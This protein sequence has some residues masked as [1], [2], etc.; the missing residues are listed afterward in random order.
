MT[1]SLLCALVLA[2]PGADAG[3]PAP[4]DTEPVVTG[5]VELEGLA[6]PSSGPPG[7]LDG[8]AVVTPLL[9][10]HLGTRVDAELGP[11]LRLRLLDAAPAER[12]TDHWGVLR[13]ADWDSLSDFGALLHTLRVGDDGTPARL[14][15][16]SLWGVTLGLGHL[17]RRFSNGDDPDSHPAGARA[18]LELGA[19]RVEALASDVLA[20]RVF[21]LELAWDAG[22]TLFS[23]AELA[24]RFFLAGSVGVDAAKGPVPFG[25]SSGACASLASSLGATLLQLDLSVVLVRSRSLRLL[26]EG[27]GGARVNAAFDSGLAVGLVADVE[28]GELALSARVELR[29]VGGGFRPGFFGPLYDLARWSDTGFHEAPRASAVLPSGVGLDGELRV[30]VGRALSAA[31]A[32]ETFPAGRTDLDASITLELMRSRLSAT[33]RVVAQGLG[34]A[35]RTFV[36]G[37]ARLRFAPSLYGVA[38]GGTVFLVQP[39]GSLQRGVFASLGAGL[40]FAR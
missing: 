9:G 35:P 4:S 26:V 31:L 22:R 11:P 36:Q 10:F 21:A 39:D 24:D 32:V 7:A 16:G 2:A 13:G 17:V 3:A 18:S 40:D 14:R 34:T 27:G 12:T 19:L 28:A 15:L 1:L 37:E 29:S 5:G 33:G 25:C 8:Y 6:F 30:E 23:S 38:G 20:A